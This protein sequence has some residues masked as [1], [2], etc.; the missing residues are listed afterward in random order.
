MAQANTENPTTQT[1]VPFSRAGVITDLVLDQVT[2]AC[3]AA[4]NGL[5]L[6]D[7][8]AALILL[9]APQICEELRQRRAAMDMIQTASDMGNVRYIH[10]HP[11]ARHNG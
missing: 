5:G 1:R 2:D 8:Q 6:T 3:A 9:T 10:T 11:D 7:D 4:Q